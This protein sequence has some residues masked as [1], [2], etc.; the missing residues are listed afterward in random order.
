MMDDFI[1][2]SESLMFMLF[3]SISRHADL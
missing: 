1:L 3:K 2:V